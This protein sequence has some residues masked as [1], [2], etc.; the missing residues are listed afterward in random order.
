MFNVP[1]TG[2]IMVVIN[3]ILYL[4]VRMLVPRVGSVAIVGL[5]T[6]FIRFI[7]TPGFSITPG[8]AIF[9][10]SLIVEVILSTMGVNIFSS[11][12]S[13]I[14]LQL[15]VPLFRL[16]SMI[17]VY[18]WE[19][20]D[21]MYRV[22]NTILPFFIRSQGMLAVII[23]ALFILII[24]GIITGWLSFTITSRLIRSTESHLPDKSEQNIR[25]RT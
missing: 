2:N 4:A 6:A 22:V 17:F 13:G 21:A 1:V 10:E 12:I 15:F 7:N 9:M 8:L 20:R 3:L 19:M 16:F 18:G 14:S 11:V 25:Y 5:V 23:G 24:I